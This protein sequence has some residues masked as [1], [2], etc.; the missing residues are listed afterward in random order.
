[1]ISGS[2]NKEKPM[3]RKLRENAAATLS[4]TLSQITDEFR[5]RQLKYLSDIQVSDL[6][7]FHS[8][9]QNCFRIVPVTW[10]ITLSQQIH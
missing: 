2:H 4:L 8:A 10:T 7:K 9:H 6:K 3:Q 1:M 5:G